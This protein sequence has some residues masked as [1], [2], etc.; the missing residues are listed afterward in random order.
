MKIKTVIFIKNYRILKKVVRQLKFFFMYK[1][2]HSPCFHSIRIDI[3][4]E[5]DPVFMAVSIM[6]SMWGTPRLFPVQ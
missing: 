5:D 1:A 6:F 3:V 2:H 4:L